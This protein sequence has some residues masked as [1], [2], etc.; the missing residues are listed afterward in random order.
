[1][2]TNYS[3]NG[4]YPT[5]PLTLPSDGDIINEAVLVVG[6]LEPI[7]DAVGQ[8][9][10]RT[11]TAVQTFRVAPALVID[12]TIG[13]SDGTIYNTKA[14]WVLAAASVLRADTIDKSTA[15]TPEDGQVI[16]IKMEPGGAAGRRLLR[17]DATI[18]ATLSQDA[19]DPAVCEVYYDGTINDW[20]L[21]LYTVHVTPG[22]SA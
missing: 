3:P 11:F 10:A 5:F 9:A 21:G 19:V 18:I 12:S 4:T 8:N 17:E 13:D 6:I 7:I 2:S 15:P 1:M 20:R 22:P 16:K 14:F